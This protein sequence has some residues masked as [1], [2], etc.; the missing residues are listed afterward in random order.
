MNTIRSLLLVLALSA[1]SLSAQLI[2]T[3]GP[4][5]PTVFDAMRAD[6]AFVNSTLLNLGSVSGGPDGDG[7]ILA[8]NYA[9]LSFNAIPNLSSSP[10]DLQV[11]PGFFADVFYLG[12]DSS[13]DNSFGSESTLLGADG[14]VLFP[15]YGSLTTNS[16]TITGASPTDLIFY[17]QGSF[18]WLKHTM[19]EVPYFTTFVASD[20]NYQYII[21]GIDDRGT[22]LQDFDDG[23][24]GVRLNLVEVAELE[25]VPE[26]STYGMI[27]GA[28]LI[29][30]V[31]SRRMRS[32][33]NS[34]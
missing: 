8:F 12:K 27:A 16:W 29:A 7:T 15:S 22:Q 33:A 20:T 5:T 11:G 21:F 14:M 24:F 3:P 25:P 1:G 4:L 10:S 32:K 28:A 31:L 18:D 13:D 23:V 34:I 6:T 17:H 19:D 26:P 9:G 2:Y 30:L